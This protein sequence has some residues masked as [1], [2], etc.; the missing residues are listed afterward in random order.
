MEKT[1]AGSPRSQRNDGLLGSTNDAQ[2]VDAR[3]DRQLAQQARQ[4]AAAKVQTNQDQ[5]PRAADEEE[6]LVSTPSPARRARVEKLGESAATTSLANQNDLTSDS[7][8]AAPGSANQ[9]A[10]AA[11][12]NAHARANAATTAKE[13]GAARHEAAT[14]TANGQDTARYGE[15]GNVLDSNGDTVGVSFDRFGRATS[16][17]GQKVNANQTNQARNK[18]G[19]YSFDADGNGAG[20]AGGTVICTELYRQ[21]LIDKHVYRAD[22]RF[23]L[24]LLRN[25]PDVIAGYHFWAQSVVHLM[26]KSRL[27]TQI[28]YKS[29]GEAWA[30]EMALREGLNGIGTVRGK[31]V[32]A[33]GIPVCRA[34]GRALT[35]LRKGASQLA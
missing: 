8:N 7:A 13:R 26:R 27:F 15:K 6:A 30:R 25:D 18:D 5:A 12:A 9:S 19:T 11:N 29:V 24:R 17:G 32:I 16:V 2:S 22:Q 20:D 4:A 10:R 3:T 31:L 21:G 35:A 23:G 34:I 1:R 14:R 28:V 33:I